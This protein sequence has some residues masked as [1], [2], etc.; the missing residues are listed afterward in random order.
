M[1][2]VVNSQVV[3]SNQMNDDTGFY[4]LAKTLE[5]TK[6]NPKVF[7]PDFQSAVKKRLVIF[8]FS[9]LICNKANEL[10]V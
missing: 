7:K 10:L 8:L 3:S 1:S 6:Q 5:K 4:S 9:S 2:P